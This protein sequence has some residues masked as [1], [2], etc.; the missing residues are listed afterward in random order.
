MTEQ[1]KSIK[2]FE[3][4]EI[5][6]AGNARKK[7]ETLIRSDG[8]PYTF[9]LKVLKQE[10]LGNGLLRI[11]LK[12]SHKVKKRIKVHILVAEYFVDKNDNDNII[13]HVD[14]NL[15]N[16]NA[17]NLKWSH[18]SVRQ[19]KILKPLSDKKDDAKNGIF[20]KAVKNFEGFYEVSNMGT[21]RSLDRVVNDLRWGSSF[22]KGQI[23]N[24]EK[25]A[26][27]SVR[28]SNNSISKKRFK[29][30]DLVCNAFIRDI[31]FN[32]YILFKNNNRHDCSV[33]NIEIEKIKETRVT[34]HLEQEKM[35]EGEI[36]KTVPFALKYQISSKGRVRSSFGRLMSLSNSQDYTSVSVITDEK[37]HKT[38]RVHRL[39][40][41]TFIANPENKLVVNHKNGDKS[42]NRVENLE[43]LTQSENVLHAHNNN[44]YGRNKNNK[45]ENKEK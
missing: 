3:N 27:L 25:T 7:E 43:W 28:L 10:L 34:K 23:L 4:Y 22:V 8:K 42:D 35:L 37:K 32:E 30:Q 44:L 5:S 2:G 19:K 39:V 40:A 20:W 12:N 26:S 21:I 38:I 41:T 11:V 24:P 1:W 45:K 36:W 6:N 14:G 16:N 13:S 18:R 31:E 9:E 33:F 17:S 15:Q 29:V